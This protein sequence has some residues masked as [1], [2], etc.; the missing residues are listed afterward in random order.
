MAAQYDTQPWQIDLTRKITQFIRENADTV[1]PPSSGKNIRLLDYAC[2]TGMITKVRR[3]RFQS[4]RSAET[5][6]ST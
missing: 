1:L 3:L 2:G 4:D 6:E 5:G